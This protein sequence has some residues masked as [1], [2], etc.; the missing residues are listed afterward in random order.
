MLLTVSCGYSMPLRKRVSNYHVWYNQKQIPALETN[1]G[2]NQNYQYTYYVCPVN[3][4]FQKGGRYQNITTSG[5]YEIILNICG[6][7]RYSTGSILC[8]HGKFKCFLLI[9][10]GYTITSTCK[11]CTTLQIRCLNYASS[12][13]YLMTHINRTYLKRVS[14]YGAE[15]REHI[16]FG[17]QTS[18]IRC[19]RNG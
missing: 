2:Y 17:V 6:L 7:G 13:Y 3:S 4:S 11:M 5:R 18:F 1:L 19:L 15:I 14:N 12:A 16:V 8:R 9:V 10:P